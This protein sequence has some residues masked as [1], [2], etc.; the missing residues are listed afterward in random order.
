[1]VGVFDLVND[2]VQQGRI[3]DRL[4]VQSFGFAV[5]DFLEIRMVKAHLLRL[6]CEVSAVLGRMRK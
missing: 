4:G 5:F 2:L 6:E 1:V 3:V